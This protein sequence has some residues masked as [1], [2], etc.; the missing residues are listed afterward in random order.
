VVRGPKGWSAYGAI[1]PAERSKALD[2]LGFAKQLV[3]STFAGTQY[4]KHE[5]LDARYGGIRAHNRA[6]AEF[7]SADKRLIP[8]AQVSLAD[9]ARAEEEIGEAVRLGCGAVWIPSAPTQDRSPGHPDLIL[10]GNR[11]AI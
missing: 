9:T 10:S 6:I 1:D 5:D 11:C 3:F 8:V 2:D 4:W 7:C